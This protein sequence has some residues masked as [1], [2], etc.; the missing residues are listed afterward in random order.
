MTFV[1]EGKQDGAAGANRRVIPPPYLTELPPGEVT[2]ATLLK[3]AGYSTAHFG[4]WHLGR[5]DPRRYGFDASDGPTDNGGPD[6]V[7]NPH[8]QQLY[9]MV[10]RGREFMTRQV[11]AG[12]PFYLQLSHYASRRGSEASSEARAAVQSWA[13]GLSERETAEAAADLDLDL[14]LGMVLKSIDDLGIADRTYVIF[15]TDH[16][17]PGHN[18]PFQGGKGTVWEGGLRV[19]CIIAGQGSNRGCAPTYASSARICSP[20][21]SNWHRSAEF[22]PRESRAAAWFPFSPLAASGR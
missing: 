6:R 1:G 7:E 3:Q 4:K 11:H 18:S 14:A 17:S 21:C 15:T 2:I 10:E 12:K 13:S 19:P 9:G 16:G 20:R 8:P 22:G 5:I